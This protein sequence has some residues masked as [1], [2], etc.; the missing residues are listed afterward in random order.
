MEE[1]HLEAGIASTVLKQG[2]LCLL[3]SQLYSVR[4][5]HGATTP[6]HGVAS[7]ETDT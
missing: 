3:F 1:V 6:V 2:I 7:S 5:G 4:G